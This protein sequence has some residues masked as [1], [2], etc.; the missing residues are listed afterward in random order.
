M[1]NFF[2]YNDAQHIRRKEADLKIKCVLFFFSHSHNPLLCLFFVLSFYLFVFLVVASLKQMA[3]IVVS[4]TNHICN[5][6]S[7]CVSTEM[8]DN[9]DIVSPASKGGARENDNDNDD[10]DDDDDTDSNTDNE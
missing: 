4:K 8:S 10:N 1:S 2:D 7:H 5:S 9:E 3:N 6:G